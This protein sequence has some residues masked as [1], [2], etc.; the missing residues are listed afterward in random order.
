MVIQADLQEK[1]S[2]KNIP[3]YISFIDPTKVLDRVSKNELFKILTNI[4]SSPNCKVL[5]IFSE[6][7]KTYC[8]IRWT[9]SK[10]FKIRND[11]K[12]GRSLVG[13]CKCAATYNFLFEI[14][15]SFQLFSLLKI[16]FPLCNLY[17]LVNID[18]CVSVKNVI[19]LQLYSIKRLF[20][21]KQINFSWYLYYFQYYF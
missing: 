19:M 18:Y 10:P 2:E 7:Y 21:F 9:A 6:E 15:L 16:I 13:C 12:Q 4:G 17:Y 3:L 20:I 1:F 11:F 5:S 14:V 8:R